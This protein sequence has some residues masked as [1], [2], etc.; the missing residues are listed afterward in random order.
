[1]A[2]ISIN[3]LCPAG[4]GLF[5]D[6]ENYLRELSE[7][8]FELGEVYGGSLLSAITGAVFSAIL[9]AVGGYKLTTKL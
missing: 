5:A 1:M 6:E 3:N 7:T 8:E 4:S 2:T 9:S